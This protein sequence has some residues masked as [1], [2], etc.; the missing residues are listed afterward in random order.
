MCPSI[1]LGDAATATAALTAVDCQVNQ[2]VGDA[3]ARLFA[4]GGA[5]SL[6][7]TTLLTIYVALVAFSLLSGRTRMT[8]PALAP[9]AIVFVLVLTF[10]TSWQAYQV[11]IQGLLSAG[12]DQIASTLM[13]ASQGATHAFAS[14]LDMLFTRVVDAAQ[15]INALDPANAQN[16]GIAKTLV[17]SSGLTLLFATLG[18]LV[19]TR[20]ILALLLGL[21]PVF[22]VLAL[23]NA[24]RGIFDAWLRTTV[25]I[26]FTPMLIVLAGSGVM[27]LLGPVIAT[28]ARD[29]AGAVQTLR[30]IVT[31]TLGAAIYA[32]L[33]VA[34]VWTAISLTRGW[35]VSGRS[36]EATTLPTSTGNNSA[37]EL[38][39]IS[40]S[41]AGDRNTA[42]IRAMAR[43][44]VLTPAIDFVTQTPEPGA[45]G[46]PRTRRP[47]LGRSYR[48]DMA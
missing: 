38:A 13:G 28:I 23:F 15:S 48:T 26:A 40:I 20:V 22:V 36:R 10:A 16:A 12:P 11:V 30:P 37:T 29:P 9:K 44:P 1:P 6:A 24:T 45:L 33:I 5:L 42:L 39:N 43:A 32:L 25:A 31:L 35:N 47:G 7:L 41:R 2:G 19:T 14:R 27:A 46:R 4:G 3:Y 34:A 17:W 8:L 18:L 21:G